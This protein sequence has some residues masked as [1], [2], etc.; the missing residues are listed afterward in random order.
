MSFQEQFRI[1]DTNAARD[2]HTIQSTVKDLLSD[3]DGHIYVDIEGLAAT[4]LE[5]RPWSGPAI[6][7]AREITGPHG[8][9]IGSCEAFA[10]W[11]EHLQTVT[12]PYN[13]PEETATHFTWL[14]TTS[15]NSS[16][17]LSNCVHGKDGSRW[18][19]V[20][21]LGEMSIDGP[22]RTRFHNLCIH[23]NEV[24]THQT[25]RELLHGFYLCGG[26]LEIWVFDRAGI[27]GSKAVDVRKTPG[28]LTQTLASYLLMD[29][30]SLG[31]GDLIKHDHVGNYIECELD[32]P[33]GA[34][35]LY[36]GE[37]TIF[38]RISK[39]I[40]GDGLTC[41][42]A[43]AQGS[44][45]WKYAVKVKWSESDDKSEAGLLKLAMEKRVWGVIRLIQH[46]IVCGTSDWRC[47][48]I[49]GEP[50]KFSS[51]AG[52]A[53]Q[54]SPGSA[55]DHTVELSRNEEAHAGDAP[56]ATIDDRILNCVVITPLGESLHHC[57]SVPGLLYALRD[58][59]KGHRS[60]Y[61]DGGILHRDICPGNIIIPSRGAGSRDSHEAKGVLIDLDVAK[62][63]TAPSRQFESV[64]TPHF[65]A[66]GVLQAYLPDNPHTYWHDLEAFFYTFLFL[67]ICK[68]PVPA[69]ENQLQ[70]PATSALQMWIQGRPVD[71]ANRKTKDMHAENFRVIMAEFTP[72]FKGLFEL[73]EKLR[74]PLFPMRDGKLWTG[75]DHTTQGTAALYDGMIEAFDMAAKFA[76]SL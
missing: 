46:R 43:K 22:Y 61:Q 65:Q 67:A 19:N 71:K 55:I 41:Y 75:T 52:A 38:E 23:A 54:D 24:F 59:I 72:D 25:A 70:L 5:A 13:V 37:P 53:R 12:R 58:A 18:S 35:R 33:T 28:L 32:G 7:V 74:C 15:P 49:L 63:V 16:L 26:V 42:R 21:A 57:K 1:E 66:I 64:G 9:A 30:A 8:P 17:I 27:Y 14:E 76:C 20:L 62:L 31:V 47:G 48:L 6:A 45:Y 10:A 39:T 40:V 44:D 68:R 34:S 50:R 29:S 51:W 3:F 60:L 4:F 56:H 2:S 11:L 36:L 73:A 69:G